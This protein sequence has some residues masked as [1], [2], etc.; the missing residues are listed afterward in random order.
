MVSSIQRTA[1]ETRPQAGSLDRRPILIVPYMWIGDFVRCHSVVKLLKARFPAR[2][3]DVLSTTLCAPLADY[4]PELRQA[5]RGRPA[6][7]APP[8]RRTQALAARLRREGY[9]TALIMPRTWKAALAPFLAGIPERTGWV[10]EWRFGLLNDLRFGERKR[11]R[12]VDQCARARPARR[13]SAAGKL[14]AAGTEGAARRGR[15]AGASGWAR[16]TIGRPTVALAPG[17]VG[18]SKR[19]P[20][21][22]YAELAR[23]LIA[24]RRR[25]LGARRARAKRRWCAIIQTARRRCAISPAP[26]CATRSWRSRRP[27]SRCRTTSACCMSRPRSARRRSAFS[28][29]PARGIGRRSIR[30]PRRDADG[31]DARLPAL[32]QAD[33]PRAPSSLHAQY[34]GRSGA[35]RDA[36]R[37]CAGQAQPKVAIRS[38]AP[39]TSLDRRHVAERADDLDFSRAERPMLARARCRRRSR[40]AA[41]R[42]PPRDAAARYR[43]RPRMRRARSSARPDRAAAGPGTRAFGTAAAISALRRRSASLPHG[44]TRRISARRERLRRARSS[45]PPA[46]PFRAARSRAADTTS[47]VRCRPSAARSSPKSGGPSGT[48]PS[49]WPVSMRLRVIACSAR[50]TR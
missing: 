20:A 28:A 38:T 47:R 41:R 44:S 12:M 43:R 16:P 21:A 23:R 26:I 8:A 2:P 7:Q 4:M 13:R 30:S 24:S 19:W 45:A 17:A 29:R 33:L 34:F 36:A 50:S 27:T 3:V 42:A 18:P 35:R 10:G 15:R 40:P 48:Y 9:G 46:I 1:P 5:H 32:P 11:P 25:R 37:A 22:A 31:R 39:R 49:A 14:A 6:A